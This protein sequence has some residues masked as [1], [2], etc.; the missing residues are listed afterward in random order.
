MTAVCVFV[1]V[2]IRARARD[3]LLVADA[4]HVPVN[5]DDNGDDS[6]FQSPFFFCKDSDV[7]CYFAERICLKRVSIK[8]RMVGRKAYRDWLRRII[9]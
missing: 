2:C 6:L 4:R 8:L 1:Y 3:P 9:K 7:C 5:N